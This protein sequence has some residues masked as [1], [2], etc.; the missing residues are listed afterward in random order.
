[1]NKLEKLI[2]AVAADLIMADP[3]DLPALAGVHE[4]FL[5]IVR[6]VK[7]DKN[8]ISE[9]AG[10]SAAFVERIILNEVTDKKGTIE[11]LNEGIAGMQ[12][13]VRDGRSPEECKF[14]AE[15]GKEDC[16]RVKAKKSGKGRRV[17]KQA[18]KSTSEGSSENSGEKGKEEFSDEP[19]PSNDASAEQAEPMII[20]CEN[21]DSSLLGEFITEAREHCTT[22]EQ[23]LM[24]LETS[25]DQESAINAIFRSFHTIKGAAGFLDLKPI[26]V[27]AH[28][29]E[30]LLDMAR[31]GT[32]RVAGVIADVVF[33]SIDI[34]RKLLDGTEQTLKSGGQFDATLLISQIIVNLRRILENPDVATF[35]E[36]PRV[37]DIL[38][39]MGAVTQPEIDK[40]LA[41]KEYPQE[42][43]GETLVKQG[44]VPAKVVAHAL[45][46]QQSVKSDKPAATV[47]EMVKIDTE[48]LDRLVDTIGEL[49]IAES[50]VGQ[51]D[52]ILGNASPKVVRNITH[53]NKITREIQEMGMAMRLVPVRP[54]FQKLARAVRTLPENRGRRLN[55]RYRARILKSTAVLWKISAIH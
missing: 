17:E 47:K 23:M 33:D 49:V 24:D 41:K 9:V 5:G 2:D 45:R 11:M 6:E 18:Q 4:G 30:T 8:I 35:E 46:N 19:E 32:V 31:K 7:D 38:V 48:R 53:L 50:M 27:L 39:E 34:M 22:A 36:P 25:A 3:E 14:P 10:K 1:M 43:L 52:E 28:E 29:S 40:A 51:D 13:I 16:G 42:K 21:G 54:T 26:S 15:L 20:S 44:L 12:A 37:G 55:L